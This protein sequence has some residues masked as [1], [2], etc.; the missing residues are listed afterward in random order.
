MLEAANAGKVSDRYVEFWSGHR[1]DVTARHY[2]TGR[3]NMAPTMLED[4]RAAYKRCEAYISTSGPSAPAAEEIQREAAVLLLTGFK[5][6]SEADARKLVEGKSGPELADLL[7]SSAKPREQAVPVEEVP[8]LLGDGWE[9]V[10]ALN[11]TMAVLRAPT[12]SALP[13]PSST[14]AP[15]GA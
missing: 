10:S 3:P 9:F 5:G 11:G 15:P 8:K 13:Q 7:K 4:M 14:P 1:G 6:K 2:T 12:H